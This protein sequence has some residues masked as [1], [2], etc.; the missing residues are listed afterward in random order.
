MEA[1]KNCNKEIVIITKHWTNLT[2][3]QLLTI[4]KMNICINTSV[5]ALDKLYLIENAVKQYEILKKYCK[6]VLRVITAK[7]NVFTAQGSYYEKIQFELLKNDSI[8]ETVLRVN[9][10]N[11]ILKNG[12]IVVSKSLFLGKQTLASKNKKT[13]YFGNCGSCF[14]QCGLN[15]K[16]K[17]V[18]Y[19]AKP[20]TIKQLS[21]F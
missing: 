15:V 17:E 16:Q 5:S 13:T 18:L 21:L 14:E 20:G 2:D 8:I 19:P 9:K 12:V 10:N 6:S 4:S 11:Q 1:I 3:D 7:F